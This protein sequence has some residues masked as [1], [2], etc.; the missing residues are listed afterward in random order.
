LTTCPGPQL[1]LGQSPVPSCPVTSTEFSSAK[2][3]LAHCPCM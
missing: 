2:Y 1:V 3:F